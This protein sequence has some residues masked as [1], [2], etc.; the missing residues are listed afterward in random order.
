V[1]RF[2]RDSVRLPTALDATELAE[3]FAAGGHPFAGRP[4]EE[5]AAEYESWLRAAEFGRYR[6]LWLMDLRSRCRVAVFDVGDDLL[7]PET[8]AG[9]R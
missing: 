5:A 7:P 2:T 1:D 6:E 4:F 3:R 8:G 9:S